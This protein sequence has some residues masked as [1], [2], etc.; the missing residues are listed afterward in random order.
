[1]WRTAIETEDGI[2]IY[3][4]I[5]GHTKN[6]CDGTFGLVKRELKRRNAITPG[7]RVEVVQNSST[8]N[9]VVLPD[10]VG[11]T[12]WKPFLEKFYCVPILFHDSLLF[13]EDR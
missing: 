11:W 6:R 12:T 3:F 2:N 13:L 5:T 8:S 1:M 4:L 7:D 10:E 9:K